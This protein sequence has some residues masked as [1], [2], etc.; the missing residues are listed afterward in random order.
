MGITSFTL[1]GLG[2]DTAAS[3]VSGT[4]PRSHKRVKGTWQ[5]PGPDGSNSWLC[6][7][8]HQ[9]LSDEESISVGE[10]VFFEDRIFRYAESRR[11]P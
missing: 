2:V 1:N 8:N 6:G 10:R 5:D 7:W 11:D 9:F 4:V 3:G